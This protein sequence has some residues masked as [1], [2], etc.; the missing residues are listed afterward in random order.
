MTHFQDERDVDRYVEE[1]FKN[2]GLVLKKDFNDQRN[3]SD[4]LKESL[5]GSSKTEN[6]TGIGIPDFTVEKYQVPVV[7]ENKAGLK[8]LIKLTKDGVSRNERDIQGFAV[9][10]AVSYARHMIQSGKYDSVVAIG[11]AGDTE[12]NLTVAVYYVFGFEGEPKLMSKYTTLNFLENKKTFNIFIADATLTEEEKHEILI[13]SQEE[14]RFHANKLN[15][16]MNEHSV[17]V[18]ERV[19]YISGM[20]LSMQDIINNNGE[21]ILEGLTPREINGTQTEKHRD[22]VKILTQIDEYLT[23]KNVPDNKKRLMLASFDKI[24]IDADRDKPAKL[25]SLVSKNIKEG[26]SVTRQ[27]FQYVYDNVFIKIAGTAGHLDILGE[28]YS[29][30][31]IYCYIII[32]IIIFFYS[33]ILH[34]I[35][36]P[37]PRRP[38]C[39]TAASPAARP[40]CCRRASRSG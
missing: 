28:M 31:Y 35:C 30:Y 34:C 13:N 16:L 29:I 5:K 21:K 18:A 2:I 33:N 39:R 11:I 17:G 4:Y 9:N 8:K 40:P 19:I 24:A 37:C 12:E 15:K 14:L 6:K 25:S 32:I 1:R 20:L 10:G 27:I 38:L 36:S 3:M 22:G 7:I 26:A 23:N